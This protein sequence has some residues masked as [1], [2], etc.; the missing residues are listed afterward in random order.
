VGRSGQPVDTAQLARTGSDM[1]LGIA[2]PAG[3]GALLAG[4]VLYRR[5]RASA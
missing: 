1:P 4:A 5:A 3:A 2:L